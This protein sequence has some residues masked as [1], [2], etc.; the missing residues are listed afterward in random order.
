VIPTPQYFWL[1]AGRADPEEGLRARVADPVWFLTRQWQ[2][3]ELQ[4]EDAST[5]VV[6]TAT[7]QHVPV[8][9]LPDRP[10]LD[11]TVV[12]AEALLEAEPGDWWT[13][14]RRLR[15]GRAVA[16]LLDAAARARF[17][18]GA[19]PAPYERLGGEVDGRAVYESGTLADDP[20]WAEVPAP[21]IDNWSPAALDYSAA[22]G[23]HP[24]ALRAQHHPGGDLDWFSVDGDAPPAEPGPAPPPRQV[25][26]GRLGYPGAPNPRWWELE[27]HAVD[28]GGFAPDRSHLATMLLLDV[29]LAHADDWFSFP[30]PPPA[31][32]D[33]QPSS[34]VLVTLDGTTVRDSFD[35][36][37]PLSAP[38]AA[39]PGAW[40]LYHT[41]GLA[42]SRLVIWPVVVAPLGGPVLDDVLIGVDED[43][44]LA[45][46]VEL[47]AEGVEL[48]PDASTA[49]AAAQTTR[50]GSREFDYLPSTT[51]PDHWHPYQR[52]RAGDPDP[53]F[54]VPPAEVAAQAGDG[55]SGVWRQGV[56]ADL[57]GPDP[58]P[59]PG[60]LSRLI[61]GPSGDGL[62]R[63]HEIAATAIPSSGVRLRR[64][65]ML[66][67]DT[68]GRPV[69]WVE[70]RASPLTGPPVSRL[71]FDV[72]A[73]RPMGDGP[74]G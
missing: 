14:G 41:A 48:L 25:I 35:Q 37:W 33:A 24:A 6:I 45:W 53:G 42:P 63:G 71:R 58:V 69:L 2:L 5:P 68:A 65:A 13:I 30:V 36:T 10:D 54:D 47:R 44:N 12:P 8:T 72:L 28:I 29:A 50:T 31:Q 38:A 3:G 43:A 62:G 39:G 4:G 49:E 74:P 32:P 9:Y 60:P 64:R 52:V 15:L 73:E 22:L 1:E 55:R 66:A 7:P 67:R 26:P 19:L 27:D 40:S 11:P 16:P 56:L 61:G 51:L 17:T 59:R 57:T 70:R 18:F 23:A 46:A 21:V 34:G 20:A